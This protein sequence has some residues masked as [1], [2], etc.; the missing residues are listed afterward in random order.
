MTRNVESYP[1]EC[2]TG[3]VSPI[4]D[5]C[6]VHEDSSFENP[7]LWS[8]VQDQPSR[9]KKIGLTKTEPEAACYA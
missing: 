7:L 9:E 5:K 4:Q 3:L 2:G 8:L 6:H 1:C